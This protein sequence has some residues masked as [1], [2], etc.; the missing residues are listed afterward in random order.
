M[1]SFVFVWMAVSFLL[2]GCVPN[3]P[4]NEQRVTDDFKL[5]IEGEESVF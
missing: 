1:N 2:A 5:V 4:V 3:G